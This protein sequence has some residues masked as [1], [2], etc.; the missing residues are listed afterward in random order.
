MRGGKKKNWLMLG[1]YNETYGDT[2]HLC[3]CSPDEFSNFLSEEYGDGTE[4]HR[5]AKGHV[6][7]RDGKG[8]GFDIFIWMP[9]FSWS[10]EDQ[11]T[12]A[13]ELI[14]VTHFIFK[15][16]GVDGGE[17]AGEAFAYL[18][19]Y[20]FRQFWFEL[21]KLYEE[22]K[23][24]KHTQ[25]SGKIKP[26]KGRTRKAAGTRERMSKKTSRPSLKG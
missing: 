22:G 11:S 14:H 3:I 15:Q 25:S 8:G 20:F 16:R 18:Y 5:K 21:K 6:E 7:W 10:V 17:G 26:T 1:V 2:A 9:K 23:L 24:C 12:L 19:S 13:H 4:I